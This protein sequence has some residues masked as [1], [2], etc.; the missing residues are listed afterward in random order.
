M[1]TQRKPSIRRGE[2][3]FIFAIV[4]G[5]IVGVLIK[6]VKLGILIGLVLGFTIVLLGWLRTTKNKYD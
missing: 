4:L 1:A 6:R 5:L 3:A 2:M